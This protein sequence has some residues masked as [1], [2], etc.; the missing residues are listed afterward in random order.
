MSDVAG[1]A[2][3]EE[4]ASV[5]ELKVSEWERERRAQGDVVFRDKGASTPLV[6][7]EDGRGYAVE[8]G[9]GSRGSY[10]IRASRR[11]L[12]PEEAAEVAVRASERAFR[13]GTFA[14]GLTAANVL[15][16]LVRLIFG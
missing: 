1:A 10:R 11:R 4:E 6:L 9:G 5:T 7:F 3:W 14:L 2:F 12:T 15:I 13:W 16:W 8:P